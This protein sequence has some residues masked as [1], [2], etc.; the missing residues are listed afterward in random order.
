MKNYI[1][2]HLF[3]L[4][5]CCN[6]YEQNLNPA[7]LWLYTN[8][9]TKCVSR[10][11]FLSDIE[12]QRSQLLMKQNDETNTLLAEFIKEHNLKNMKP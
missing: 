8:S 6:M 4:K 1:L 5:L 2:M 11:Y 3:V 12:E 7:K 10:E 9:L